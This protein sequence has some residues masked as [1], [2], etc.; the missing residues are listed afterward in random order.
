MGIEKR[1]MNT[2]QIYH[3]SWVKHQR[4]TYD[5]YKEDCSPTYIRMQGDVKK[6]IQ[7][8]LS[9]ENST[10]KEFEEAMEPQKFPSILKKMVKQG[11]TKI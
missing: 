11:A 2:R 7:N 9:K 3:E 1:F 4:V 6:L 10:R 8:E 5:E